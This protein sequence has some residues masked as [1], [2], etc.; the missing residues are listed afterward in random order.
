ML[1]SLITS[2]QTIVLLI[3]GIILKYIQRR[4]RRSHVQIWRSLSPTANKRLSSEHM[5]QHPHPVWHAALLKKWFG[6]HPLAKHHNTFLEW[7]FN[8]LNFLFGCK[9]T[10]SSSLAYCFTEW[11]YLFASNG[12]MRIMYWVIIFELLMD[13]CWL[14]NDCV[15]WIV[16][17][18]RC[19]AAQGMQNKAVV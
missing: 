9:A 14:F 16:V 17:T 4:R 5:T 11:V 1:I 13:L 18:V 2:R 7:Y 8:D 3:L 12:R 6:L 10:S 15:C 19:L